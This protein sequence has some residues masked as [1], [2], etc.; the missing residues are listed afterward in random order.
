MGLAGGSGFQPKDRLTPHPRQWTGV[1]TFIAGFVIAFQQLS[2]EGETPGGA[3]GEA[4]GPIGIAI[5]AAAGAQVVLAHGARPDPSSPKRRVWNLLHHWLG[6]SVI[7]LA[8]A[9]VY[10]GIYAYHSSQW[11]ASYREWVTPIAV[12]MGTLVLAD[13][14]LRL[15]APGGKDAAAPAR[16]DAYH[17][18]AQGYEQHDGGHGANGN[19]ANGAGGNGIGRHR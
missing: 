11:Q 9:N 4:H 5:M 7:L 1:A 2:D 18:D 19:G 12:V 10:I 8:W 16:G 6:R 13:L 15:A 17:V 14:A 3:V